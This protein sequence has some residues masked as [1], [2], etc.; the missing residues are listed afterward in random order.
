MSKDKNTRIGDAFSRK[1]AVC[2]DKCIGRYVID[3]GIKH[4]PCMY[5]NMVTNQTNVVLVIDYTYLPTV[6]TK[7]GKKDYLSITPTTWLFMNNLGITSIR[8]WPEVSWPRKL[9]K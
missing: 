8:V 6:V 7:H 2:Q 1:L 3:A 5:C 4:K 9:P